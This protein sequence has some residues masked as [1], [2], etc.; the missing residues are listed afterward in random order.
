MAYSF[1]DEEVR[2][3]VKRFVKEGTLNT[4]RP[5]DINRVIDQ[6]SLGSKTVADV[7]ARQQEERQKTFNAFLRDTQRWAEQQKRIFEAAERAQKQQE[8]IHKLLFSPSLDLAKRINT[9]NARLVEQSIRQTSQA[10]AALEQ[11]LK[12]TL[13]KFDRIGLLNQRYELAS[14]LLQPQRT[15]VDFAEHTTRRL[16]LSNSKQE[17]DALESSLRLAET[18]LVAAT[19]IHSNIVVVPSDEEE[20]LDVRLLILPF[21]QQE[22]LLLLP[23]HV[24]QDSTDVSSGVPAMHVAA[25]GRKIVQL[26]TQCNEAAKLE[27]GNEIFKPTTKLIVVTGDIPWILARDRN[28][29]ADF[30]DC[31]YFIF[32][33]GA[34]KD[35]LRFLTDVD[36]GVLSSN[37]PECDLIWCIKHLR[38]KWTRHDADHGKEG[39]IRK[40]W[41]LLQ[42]KFVWLGLSHYPITEEHFRQLHLQLLNKSVHFLETVAN[43]LVERM[44]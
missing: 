42:E 27:N 19:E 18:Q 4:K 21:V 1:N 17:T 14:R 24:Q 44:K 15:F 7:A 13:P 35:K 2:R 34:G 38:N 6:M 22:E 10:S 3:R 26:V 5:R 8:Q 37:D 11:S 25:L 12:Y 23:S 33:E 29:F 41:K 30:V 32:Y 39:E 9:H 28:S 20:V 16:E 31:L 43:K 36:G 40:S